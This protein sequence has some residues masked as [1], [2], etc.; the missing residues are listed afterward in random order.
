MQKFIQFSIITIVNLLLIT[1]VFYP[2][3]GTLISNIAW[4]LS[5]IFGSF[6]IV[7]AGMVVYGSYQTLIKKRFNLSRYLILSLTFIFALG[8]L[9]HEGMIGFAIDSFTNDLVGSLIANI[10]AIFVIAW[11]LNRLNF[12]NIESLFKKL[13]QTFKQKFGPSKQPKNEKQSPPE[14][15]EDITPKINHQPE[16]LSPNETDVEVGE[17][18]ELIEDY[19]EIKPAPQMLFADHQNYEY[20][21]PKLDLLPIKVLA[22][23]SED[24]NIQDED[25]K[26]Q[27]IQSRLKI[28]VSDV[29]RGPQVTTFYL[30]TDT[31]PDA[32]ALTRL[33]SHLGLG[34]D[35]LQSHRQIKG[36]ASTHG[37]SIPNEHRD[38]VSIRE[39]LEALD[40][41]NEKQDPSKL[42]FCLGKNIYNE[43]LFADLNRIQHMFVAGMTSSGK[44]IAL[45][46]IICSL[47]YRHSPSNL[48]LMLFTPKN[49]F[50]KYEK[51]PHLPMHYNIIREHQSIQALQ[52]LEAENNRRKALFE[53]SDSRDFKIFNEKFPEKR[54]PYLIVIIDEYPAFRRIEGFDDLV[55][56]F[57][58]IMRSSGIY[59]ILAAQKPTNQQIPT[60][61]TNNLDGRWGFKL[62]R[63]DDFK[64]MFN[65][66]EAGK[67]NLFKSGDSYFE[68][69]SYDLERLQAPFNEPADLENFINSLLFAKKN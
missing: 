28:E 25:S 64:S 60:T 32:K 41:Q 67:N 10:L 21:A 18:F 35:D 59:F 16:K 13:F 55:A 50:D 63:I 45:E 40:A 27:L 47:V 8:A 12:F 38:Y 11:C 33:S 2:G 15:S 57:V 46:S 56:H 6:N 58:S 20:T 17:N 66:G 3:A 39:C 37:I 61:V 19:E 51:L 36:R 22:E 53:S 52:D 5:L 26:K 24:S 34:N 7:L 43:I 42:L 23:H 14:V 4:V 69:G 1:A 9:F 62:K 68:G 49:D 44:S 48:K 29:I 30:K 65:R 31:E 54:L